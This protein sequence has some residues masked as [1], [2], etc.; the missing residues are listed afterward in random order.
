MVG[1]AL[2]KIRSRIIV[3]RLHRSQI[4]VRGLNF[5][6]ELLSDRLLHLSHIY[7]EQ[8]G[9]DAHIDHVFYQLAQLGLRTDGGHQFVVGNRIK[10]QIITK[11]A[12]VQRFVAKGDC[13]RRQRHDVFPRRLRIHSHQEIDFLLAGDVTVFISPDRVPGRQPGNV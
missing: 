9:D 4:Q 11:R 3:A 12:Q 7:V 8:L 6:G 13:A 5:L 10:H 1:I 2:E